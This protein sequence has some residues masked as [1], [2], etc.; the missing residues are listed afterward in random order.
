MP[1][2]SKKSLTRIKYGGKT[3]TVEGITI[4]HPEREVFPGSGISKGDVAVYYAKA[5]PYLL[6]FTTGRL[7]SLLR[8]TRNV[9]GECFFQRAPMK[10]GNGNIHRLIVDHKGSRHNYFYIDNPSGIIELVQ[11]GAVE[12]HGWQSRISAINQ[13][14]Q[15]IFDLD[16]AENIPFD[17]IKRAA[18]DVRN[19]L[20][21]AGLVSFPRLSGGK[22]I[23]IAV[24][25]VPDHEWDQVK[26]FTQN[27]ARQMERDAPEV[28]IST[29]SK[30]K[31]EGKIF[32]DYLRNDFSATAIIPF[33]LRARANAPIATP[34]LWDK[35]KRVE[36]A[37]QFNFLNIGG[38]LNKRM[39]KLVE[40]FFCI[41]QKLKL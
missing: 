7:I 39:E 1:P 25:I 4:T 33:S 13:P 26:A 6:P 16:P 40:E 31:R 24:P 2:S 10:G 36:S 8:C 22:G 32:I 37:A 15:I 34:V 18:L 12:L 19:R 30:K 35:L 14:D 21:A 5:M 9:G 27:L 28:Y 23:H 3:F 11:M 17:A 20:K 38:N 41:H 29:M